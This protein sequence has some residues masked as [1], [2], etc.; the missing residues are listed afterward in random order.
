VGCRVVWHC[1]VGGSPSPITF[2]AAAPRRGFGKPI[3]IE[4]VDP[5]K[6]ALIVAELFDDRAID[7]YGGDVAQHRVRR[8]ASVRSTGHRLVQPQ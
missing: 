3:G 4:L 7:F 1:H 5:G 6:D 2:G 8:A